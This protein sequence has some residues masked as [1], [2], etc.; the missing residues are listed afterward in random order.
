MK[1]NLIEVK[2]N[3]ERKR[4]RKQNGL[5]KAKKTIQEKQQKKKN[6]SVPCS[7]LSSWVEDGSKPYLLFYIT[8][9]ATYQQQ[10]V[11]LLLLLYYPHP[12]FSSAV[13]SLSPQFLLTR[14]QFILN[15]KNDPHVKSPSKPFSFPPGLKLLLLQVPDFLC[16]LLLSCLFY[17]VVN[18]VTV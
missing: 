1:N 12:T 4:D 9:T 8:T 17:V 13:F 18:F 16:S 7:L 10:H 11:L 14:I 2:K 5:R 6:K 15:R 3:L